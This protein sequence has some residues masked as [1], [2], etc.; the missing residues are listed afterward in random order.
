MGNKALHS[1]SIEVFLDN[2]DE[3]KIFF[4]SPKD[5][6]FHF[7]GLFQFLSDLRLSIIKSGK[8]H[9]ERM[10]DEFETSFHFIE[11][12]TSDI[13]LVRFRKLCTFISKFPGITLDLGGLTEQIY[14]YNFKVTELLMD[15]N[16]FIVEF[17][18]N[19]I[20]PFSRLLFACVQ[21][22]AFKNETYI[23][24]LDLLILLVKRLTSHRFLTQSNYLKLKPLFRIFKLIQF[25]SIYTASSLFLGKLVSLLSTALKILVNLHLFETDDSNGSKIFIRNIMVSNHLNTISIRTTSM[26]IQFSSL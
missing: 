20:D 22:Q 17:L 8:S 26:K 18:S 5:I 13:E 23:S 15:S 9:K 19:S 10:N 25:Q 12:D 2:I 16:E 7:Q 3:F 14:I 21:T 1:C 4:V 24:M 6:L 11:D